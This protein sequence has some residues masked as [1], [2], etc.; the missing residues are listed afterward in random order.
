[1]AQHEIVI[2]EAEIKRM[3]DSGLLNLD[4]LNQEKPVEEAPVEDI[5]QEPV[6]EKPAKATKKQPAKAVEEKQAIADA[7]APVEEAVVEPVENSDEPFWEAPAKGVKPDVENELKLTKGELAKRDAVI[8]KNPIIKAILKAEVEGK[9][10]VA[11]I[12]NLLL[13]DPSGISDDDLIVQ[14]LMQEEKLSIEEA[15]ERVDDMDAYLKKRLAKPLKEQLAAQHAEQFKE[16]GFNDYYESQK[17]PKE[18]EQFANDLTSQI[19]GGNG[20]KL[21]NILTQDEKLTKSMLEKVNKGDCFLPTDENGKYDADTAKLIILAKYH[22]KEFFGELA[23]YYEDKGRR[24]ALATTKA[25]R[26]IVSGGQGLAATKLSREEI[27]KDP[28]TTWSTGKA[29]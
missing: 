7:I 16:F 20:K 2:D 19:E 22:K 8:E 26:P 9:D 27:V 10:P 3:T 14:D 18:I 12:K 4:H 21:F 1:M 23:K 15:K 5:V 13:Q 6:I 25:D 11:A 29:V 17:T 28:A 24:E